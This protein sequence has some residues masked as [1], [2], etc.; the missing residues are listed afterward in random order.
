MLA[1]A[2]TDD[3]LS[4][5]Y[6]AAGALNENISINPDGTLSGAGGGQVQIGQLPGSVAV[7]QLTANLAVAMNAVFANL[8]AINAD[9][10]T[11]TAGKLNLSAQTFTPSW[12]TQFDT[13][14]SGTIS[15]V[16]LGCLVMMF[17]T[18]ALTGTSNGIDPT[19]IGSGIPSAIRPSTSRMA[20]CIVI[21]NNVPELGFVNIQNNGNFT[22]YR[23]LTTSGA[24]V[25]SA[26]AFSHSNSKGLP[27]DW[28]IVYP[29]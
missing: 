2:R 29:K 6:I 3:A 17:T 13:P 21:N 15:Y 4:M 12:E 20:P 25:P 14:P 11:V 26:S 22:L 28:M 18:A 24:P 10:G 16:D 1:L 19:F 9:L 7:G 23:A 5:A 8:A 27:D